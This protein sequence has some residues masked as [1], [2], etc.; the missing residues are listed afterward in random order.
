MA[1]FD[2]LAKKIGDV[3][4]MAVDKAKDLTEVGRLNMAI[5]SEERQLQSWYAEIGKAIY[6]QDKDNTESPY[7]EQ[8]VKIQAALDRIETLKL[9]LAEVKEN[10]YNEPI[11]IEP[12]EAKEGTVEDRAA[13]EGK[14]C[15]FCGKT[16]TEDSVFCSACGEKLS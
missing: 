11:D 2:E 5:S 7:V 8:C 9:Q 12:K 14:A 3:A 1:F 13:Q 4:D 10:G 16:V 15:P 6:E